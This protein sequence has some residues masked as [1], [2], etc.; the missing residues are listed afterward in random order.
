M[1]NPPHDSFRLNSDYYDLDSIRTLA[2][3][4]IKEGS[5]ND[6]H[7]GEFILH[8]TDNSDVQTLETSGTTASPSKV[9]ISKYSLIHSAEGTGSYFNL[10]PGDSALCCLPFSYIAGKM[11]F[12]RAWVL[13]L[14]LDIIEPS[15]FPLKNSSKYYDFSAMV[16]MQVHNA[17][18]KLNQIKTLLIGGA[19]VSAALA[20]RLKGHQSTIFE[21]Y[22]MTETVSHIA[23]KNLSKGETKF[24]TLA[25]ISL[26][27]DHNDRLIIHAPKLISHPLQ[28]NDIV[29]LISNH[30]F[31]WLGRF[32]HIINSGGVKIIPEQIE[33]LLKDQI[34]NRFFITS[35]PDKLLG[36]KT[37]MIVEG[38]PMDLNINWSK[39][40]SKK[41]P[42]AIYFTPY[43]L[44][45]SS[46]KIKRQMTL[47]SLNLNHS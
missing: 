10:K 8:W 23:V 36:Q 4:W 46:G 28:T 45:T 1:H 44:E 47:D 5:D 31:V 30:S 41:R 40:D 43:F 39:I 9:S 3:S 20:H 25:G 27:A 16:P 29:S 13:G 15:S 42:K 14:E 12:V 11:M 35:I 2:Y 26:E 37:I 38:T 34:N 33:N 6:R 19:P 24:S 22:G 21:T 18:S 7:L 17:F 32:D